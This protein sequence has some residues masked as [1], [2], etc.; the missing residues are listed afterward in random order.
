MPE[1]QHNYGSDVEIVTINDREFIIVGTAHISKQSADLVRHVIEKEKPDTVC[2]ELDQQRY[3]ALVEE[4]KWDSLDLKTI[5]KQKQLTTLLIN[6]LLGSY[7]KKLGKKLGVTPGVELLEA[8]KAADELN[9]PVELC[10]RDVRITLKR[11]W[12]SLSFFKKIQLVTSGIAGAFTDQDISEKQLVEIRQKD[13]LNE[14]MAELGKAMPVL[15]TVLIDERDG[16]LSH[17]MISVPGKKVVSIVGAGHMVGIKERLLNNKKVNLEELEQIPSPSPWV[18]II[19]WAIPAV[20]ILS[21]IFIGYSKGFTEA[22]DNALFWF[23]AN[24]IPSALGV[25]VALGH[26]LTVLSAFFGAP[27]TSLT[28]LIGAGYVAAFVQAYFKPPLVSELKTLVDDASNLKMWWR[29]K[30]LRVFLV[31]ILSTIGSAL[32]TWAGLYEILGNLF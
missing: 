27:F 2:V 31:L 24:G 4:K 8:T 14:M 1:K 32:G 20:I 18:K 26:P 16:Y 11:A 29:N 15:K 21:I 30:A 23:L 10:D 28:P 3:K 6:L 7:Q 25:I 5:T 12:N 13:V 9:I 19:G 22:G 17:K